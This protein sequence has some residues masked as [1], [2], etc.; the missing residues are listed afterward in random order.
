MRVFDS[1]KRSLTSD[2]LDLDLSNS[3]FLPR[4]E[5]VAEGIQLR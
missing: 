2:R 5:F 3:F 1:K 4:N